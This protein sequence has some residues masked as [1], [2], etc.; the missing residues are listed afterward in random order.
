MAHKANE[1]CLEVVQQNF[2]SHIHARYPNYPRDGIITE[3]KPTP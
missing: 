3:V 2:D 1:T